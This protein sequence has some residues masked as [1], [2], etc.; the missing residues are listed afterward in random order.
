MEKKRRS[1]G[2]GMIGVIEIIWG[3]IIIILSALLVRDALTS[4]GSS[5]APL[6]I[7]IGPPYGLIGL[8]FLVIG[9]FTL[10]LKP[11]GRILNLILFNLA[12]IGAIIW[13]E[14][15]FFTFPFI[16][17]PI[18]ATLII[19]FKLP[20]FVTIYAEVIIFLLLIVYLIRPKVKEQFKG[21]VTHYERL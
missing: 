11:L 16:V 2:V 6:G 14:L 19:L 15:V 10:R 20:Y 5:K 4:V 21:R 13:R 3:I 9:V 18:Q 7:V 12:I 8:F 17:A 1:I